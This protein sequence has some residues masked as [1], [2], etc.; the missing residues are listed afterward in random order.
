VIPF[1]EGWPASSDILSPC[2]DC[3]LV[4]GVKEHL[5]HVVSTWPFIVY[6]LQEKCLVPYL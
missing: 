3:F 1:S 4:Q 6:S 5:Y 2:F